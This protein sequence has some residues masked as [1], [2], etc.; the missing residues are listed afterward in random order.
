MRTAVTSS[1]E[2]TT[3]PIPSNLSYSLSRSLSILHRYSL[4]NGVR[5]W[6]RSYFTQQ[7]RVVEGFY[8]QPRQVGHGK[9]VEYELRCFRADAHGYHPLTGK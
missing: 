2:L 1:G 4:P 6:E 3:H 8:A 9:G 7:G 5:R